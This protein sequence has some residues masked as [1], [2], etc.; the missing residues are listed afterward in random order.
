MK[1]CMQKMKESKTENHA[2]L[3]KRASMDKI[4]RSTYFEQEHE[5]KDD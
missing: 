2:F 3:D 1:E 4:G 5:H